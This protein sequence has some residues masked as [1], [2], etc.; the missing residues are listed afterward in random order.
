MPKK[1]DRRLRIGVLGCGPIAQAAH[2]ERLTSADADGDVPVSREPLQDRQAIGRAV[3]RTRPVVG[4]LDV[5]EHRLDLNPHEEGDAGRGAPRG[6]VD[7]I[8]EPARR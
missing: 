3:D 1:D 7:R 5:P 4:Y 2:F 8:A 6:L